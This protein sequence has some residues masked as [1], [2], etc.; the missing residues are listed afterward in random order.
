MAITVSIAMILSTFVLGC[1]EPAD[2]T[3]PNKTEDSSG[4][5]DNTDD[6]NKDDDKKDTCAGGVIGF[7][8]NI[9]VKNESALLI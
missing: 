4:T 5:G 1:K 6:S 7:A 2:P 8:K 9:T 3:D